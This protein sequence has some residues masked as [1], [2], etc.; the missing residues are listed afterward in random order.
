MLTLDAMEWPPT[1]WTVLT[2]RE[3]LTRADCRRHLNQLREAVR[4][5]WPDSEWFVQVEFQRRGALHLNLLH[6][7][8]P[9]EHER[10]LHELLTERWCARVDAR[11]VGQWSGVV[12]DAIGTTRYISKMLAH[13]L[14]AEQAPPVGWRGHRTSQTRGYLVR[15]ASA[16]RQE[17]KKSLRLKRLLHAGVDVAAAELELAM[18]VEWSLQKVRNVPVRR[19][20]SDTRR[21]IPD[22]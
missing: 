8:V 7:G 16:M 1:L 10:E 20:Y 21:L 19:R 12:E 2:A 9:V 14:K 17:A 3:H 11:P 15:P 22:G 4:R 18:E 13:G 6:K 5:R